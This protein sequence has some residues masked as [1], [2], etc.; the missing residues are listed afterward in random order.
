MRISIIAAVLAL[1]STAFAHVG[2]VTTATGEVAV[3]GH[4][5]CIHSGQWAPE[6][7]FPGCDGMPL[8]P[9]PAPPAPPPPPPPVVVAPPADTDK[10]GVVDEADKCPETPA[11]VAVDAKGCPMDT[12]NDGVAD[13]LDKCPATP[14]TVVVDEVGCT[15]KLDKEVSIGLDVH[16]VTGKADIEGDASAE[17]AKVAS[18]MRKYPGT[19]VTIEGYTD[20]VGAAASNKKLSQKRADAVKAAIVVGGVDATRLNSVGFGPDSPVADNK[21][22][23]GRA[24]NR[25]VIAH[26]KAE[27]E[28]VEK[29][30]GV[31]AEKAEKADVKAEAKP[32]AKPEAAKPEVKKP[33]VKAEMKAEAPK[34]A[35]PKV[36]VK[37]ELNMG[38]KMDVKK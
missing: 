20:N 10:D 35:A 5:E 13:Y 11:G 9:P 22:E 12:D 18:F 25:R 17:I 30:K 23:E 31:K 16:F 19:K 37:K 36:E 2:Y 27:I 1:S 24:K 3:G 26:A 33:E 38:M 32:E 14:E 7:I 6:N 34:P 15:K 21:T 8:T 29:K 28:V 4:G